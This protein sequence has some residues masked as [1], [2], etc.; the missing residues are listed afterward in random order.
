MLFFAYFK[1]FMSKVQI[2]INLFS[3]ND[4]FI[5]YNCNYVFQVIQ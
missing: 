5:W 3:D 4:V 1:F 2:I